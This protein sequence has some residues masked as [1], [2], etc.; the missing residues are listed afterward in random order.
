KAIAPEDGATVP[1]SQVSFRWAAAEDPDGDPIV[2]YHFELSE[3]ADMRW[4]LSPNFEKLTS[5]T[6]SQ[7]KPEWTVPYVGL[8]NPDTTYHWRVR[9]RDA[10]GIWGAWS[11][12]FK[13]RVKAPGVPLDLKL[14]SDDRGGFTLHW[15][16]NPQGEPPAGYKVYGSDER[17]FT[18]SDVEHLVN[19]GKGFVRTIEEFDAK[20]SNAPDAGMVKTPS[21]LIARVTETSLPVVGPGLEQPSTNKAYYRVVAVDAAG[22]ESGPSDYAEVPRPFVVTEPERKAKVGQAYRHEVRV[23]GSIGDLRCR[24]S[25]KSSYNAAFWDREEHTF[26]AIDLPEGLSLD[27]KTGVISGKPEKPGTFDVAIAVSDQFGKRQT[28]SYRLVVED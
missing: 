1:G 20:P 5:L 28:A 7:G 15:R 21:N 27:P 8:L 22:N 24:P 9:A 19:R 10:T 14:A 3:H 26:A 25:P 11:P 18:A 6:P 4:P 17:G 2:D 16:A 23:I 12:T 13:F